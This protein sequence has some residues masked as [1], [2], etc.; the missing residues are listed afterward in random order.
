MKIIQ[1]P[2]P[3]SKYAT[4]CPYAMTP[5]FY[6]VHNTANDTNAA[7]E[8]AYMTRREDKK[9]S[10]HY[11]VD[12]QEIVQ[13][14]PETRN[15]WHAGDGVSGSGNRKGIAIE[16]CYSLSGGPKFIAAEKLAAKFIA[17]KLKEC[18]WG[19]AQ[20]KKHQDFATKYCPHR[21]LDMGWQRYLNMIGAE[22]D[23]L[24]EPKPE[25]KEAKK[26][27]LEK[28]IVIHSFAD[29]PAVE[30]LAL[31]LGVP[32]YLRATAEAKQV[33]SEIIVCGGG[34]GEIKADK[35]IDLSGASRFET[36]RKIEDYLKK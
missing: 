10:F 13:A 27:M 25:E 23:A 18:G 8:I 34:R 24:S 1:A 28:A 29:F 2:V 30:P 22:L 14:I 17:H 33:A 19:L 36:Y 7:N 6:V 21:T 32:I 12:D 3:A 5:E 16:I 31:R 35:V 9:V 4:K 11:A 26:K 20:V 15:A